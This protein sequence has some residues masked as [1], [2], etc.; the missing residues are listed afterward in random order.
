MDM[1]VLTHSPSVLTSPDRLHKIYRL[2][3][4]NISTYLPLP[5]LVAVGDR[6][7]GKSSLLESLMGIPFPRGQ[8]LCTRYTTQ[9]THR[10]DDHP[11]INISI[12]PGPNAS[13][14]DKE[15]LESYRKQVE[16]IS[17]LHAEFPEI[18]NEVTML[19]PRK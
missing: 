11:R 7:S 9:I 2:Q 15:R 14:A 10:R 17:Q 12:I 13:S 1:Q 5:Q 16:T 8:E 19:Y 3:E 4:K 6:S 18:L